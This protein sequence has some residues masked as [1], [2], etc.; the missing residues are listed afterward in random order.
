[1]PGPPDQTAHRRAEPPHTTSP[2][3][4]ACQ[5]PQGRPEAVHTDRTSPTAPATGQRW[6]PSSP[7]PRV[8]TTRPVPIG[9][10]LE[11]TEVAS[12]MKSDDSNPIRS[13]IP[14]SRRRARYVP[15]V[16][17]RAFEPPETRF[18]PRSRVPGHRCGLTPRSPLL[19]K[20]R[21]WGADSS[22]LAHADS[23]LKGKYIQTHPA[24][25]I[26]GRRQCPPQ[27]NFLPFEPS[28]TATSS[29]SAATA[30][31][32]P[33]PPCAML[34]RRRTTSVRHL[35]AADP[36]QACTTHAACTTHGGC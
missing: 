4:R 14:P 26:L 21:D 10:T 35:T 33:V 22:E 28:I 19:R 1:M 36:A 12:T 23:L 3:P 9:P 13:V 7:T 17:F 25:A 29:E 15:E 5:P 30:G 20:G 6:R 11:V 16:A 27:P 18:R 8:D 34:V 31:L 2:P 24:Q 32:A